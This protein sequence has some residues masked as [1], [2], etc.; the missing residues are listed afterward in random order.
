MKDFI[1]DPFFPE[2]PI[3]NVLA[4]I[5]GKWTMAVLY[6]LDNSV[7]PLRFRDIERLN[8]DCSQKMLTSTLRG[9]EADGLVSRKVFPE[10]PPRVE[11]SLT[12]RAQSLMPLIHQLM[13]WAYHNLH[14]IVSDREKY[15][16]KQGK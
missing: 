5:G 16:G 11:Y 7:S 1:Q 2:C 6:T 8:P 15:Y 3:R 10:V 9:L 12:D 13:D 14:D 4:R